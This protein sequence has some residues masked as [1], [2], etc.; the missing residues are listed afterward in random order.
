[1]NYL[2]NIIKPINMKTNY[3]INNFLRNRVIKFIF[4][5]CFVNVISEKVEAQQII[6]VNISNT[7]PCVPID[8]NGYY[9]LA[10][11]TSGDRPVYIRQTSSTSILLFFVPGNNRWEIYGSPY[12]LFFNRSTSTSVPLTGWVRYFSS[13]ATDPLPILSLVLPVTLTDFQVNPSSSDAVL[14]WVTASES[15]NKGFEIEYSDDATVF[16]KIGWVDGSNTTQETKKYSFIHKNAIRNIGYYRLR[17]VDYDGKFKYSNI[18][19]SRGTDDQ[20]LTVYP[21]PATTILNVSGASEGKY[22][23]FSLEGKKQKEGDFTGASIPIQ[24]LLKGIYTITIDANGKQTNQRLVK[25]D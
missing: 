19:S 3:I 24:E 23:I 16:N 15:N 10:A 5:L 21:N 20:S 13:C 1:M 14:T 7:A 4:L 12:G 18:I 9:S 6:G 17:Q 2:Y 25:L 8:A 22:I 11:V